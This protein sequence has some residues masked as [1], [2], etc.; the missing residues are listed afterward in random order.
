M[1]ASADVLLAILEA[2]AGAY[3]VPGKI[4]S[5]LC[6][7]RPVLGAIPKENLAARIIT[8]SGAGIVVDPNSTED[9]V[10][11]AVALLGD[12]GL[13]RDLGVRARQHAENHFNIETI[14]DKF[15]RVFAA[16]VPHLNHALAD[17]TPSSPGRTP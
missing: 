6:S 3:S 5:Y 8:G 10:R 1:L 4:L 17:A 14:T 11:G 7:G 9:F 13:R 15:E 12:P 16:S 2:D